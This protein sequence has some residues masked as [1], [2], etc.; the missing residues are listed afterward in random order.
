MRLVVISP[1]LD[2]AVL[3]AGGGITIARCLGIEVLIL[4]VFTA[5][6]PT[7][8]LSDYA[9]ASHRQCEESLYAD[10]HGNHACMARPAVEG[11]WRRSGPGTPTHEHTRGMTVDQDFV[12]MLDL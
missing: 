3:C 10:Q 12:H 11:Y 7:H 2:D 6:A 4:T 5:D 8:Q 9:R 1:H